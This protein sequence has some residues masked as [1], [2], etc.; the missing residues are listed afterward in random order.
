MVNVV[1]LNPGEDPPEGEDWAL[2]ARD[3]SGTAGGSV[4]HGSK[5]ATFYIPYPAL[6]ADQA[7]AI[8]KAKD[9]AK[10]HNVPTVYVVK[11]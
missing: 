11:R 8:E 9:W 10:K 5:G 4:S 6:E 7:A 2:V 1:W 3:T